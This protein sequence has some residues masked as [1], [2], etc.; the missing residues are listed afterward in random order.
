MNTTHAEITHAD[1]HT[2]NTSV[3]R[4]LVDT[5]WLHHGTGLARGRGFKLDVVGMVAG[6]VEW[7]RRDERYD[8]K[9]ATAMAL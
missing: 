6:Q 3:F 5:A 7:K 2:P 8:G 9:R 4:S 1:R